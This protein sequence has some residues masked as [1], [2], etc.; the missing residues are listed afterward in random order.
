MLSFFLPC[1][2]VSTTINHPCSL[3]FSLVSLVSTRINNSCA[4]CISLS[5]STLPYVLSFFQSLFLLLLS[6]FQ[7]SFPSFSSTLSSY[8]SSFFK[9]TNNSSPSILQYFPILLKDWNKSD[10][11]ALCVRNCLKIVCTNITYWNYLFYISVGGILCTNITYSNYL[12]YFTVEGISTVF[13]FTIKLKC[14]LIKDVHYKFFHTNNGIYTR[15][16]LNSNIS[17]CSIINT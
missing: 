16:I 7:S 4:L 10:A 8:L 1:F 14:N 17:K 12:F 11:L 15:N 9:K 3:S 5:V 6:L 2:S 13:P